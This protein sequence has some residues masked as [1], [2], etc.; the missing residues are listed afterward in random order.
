MRQQLLIYMRHNSLENH[1]KQLSVILLM[2]L[3]TCTQAFQQ[4]DY[5]VSKIDNFACSNVDSLTNFLTAINN[6]NLL[7]IKSLLDGGSCL[8]IMKGLRVH[9]RFKS[10]KGQTGETIIAIT[11]PGAPQSTSVFTLGSYYEK[12][13]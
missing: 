5:V 12:T 2:C 4:G 10:P 11:V 7:A 1:V 9:V 3:S 8:S 6:S 13:K